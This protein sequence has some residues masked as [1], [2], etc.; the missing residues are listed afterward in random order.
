MIDFEFSADV[1]CLIFIV[2]SRQT[3]AELEDAWSFLFWNGT[4][5]GAE[6]DSIIPLKKYVHYLVK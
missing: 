3:S 5:G 4:E 2:P 1:A 6:V